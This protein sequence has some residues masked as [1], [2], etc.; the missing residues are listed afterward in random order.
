VNNSQKI[1]NLLATKSDQC[2]CN[3]GFSWSSKSL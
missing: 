3:Y 2:I 1:P